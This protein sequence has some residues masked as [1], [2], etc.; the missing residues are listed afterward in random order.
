MKWVC[1]NV[2]LKD[3]KVGEVESEFGAYDKELGGKVDPIDSFNPKKVSC[4]FDGVYFLPHPT[5]CDNYYICS[6]RTLIAHSC[7]RGVSWNFITNQCDLSLKS[8]CYRKYVN[9]SSTNIPLPP[10]KST[11]L[12]TTRYV[13]PE[14]PMTTLNEKLPIC[15]L[16]VQTYYPHSEDCRKYYICIAG[17]PVLTTCPDELYWDDSNK[18]CGLPQYTECNAKKV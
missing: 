12:P 15:P 16:N 6:H 10:T 18:F 4:M 14:K 13:P 17:L 5:A 11:P 9:D 7:G 2:I 1:E 3:I 8:S